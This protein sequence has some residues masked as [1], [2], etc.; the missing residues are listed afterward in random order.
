MSLFPPFNRDFGYP[1]PKPGHPIHSKRRPLPPGPLAGSIA[2]PSPFR[3][4]YPTLGPRFSNVNLSKL[5]IT[6]FSRPLID[7]LERRICERRLMTGGPARASL[8]QIGPVLGP[9]H[10]HA[11]LM[12]LRLSW[13]SDQLLDAIM[14]DARLQ[15]PLL[16]RDYDADSESSL[17]EVRR[18][19]H[20]QHTATESTGPANAESGAS[21]KGKGAAIESTATAQP[22]PGDQ[23]KRSKPSTHVPS[24]SKLLH[25]AVD[26]N[27]P[28][29]AQRV[30]METANLGDH[31]VPMD[32][33]DFSILEFAHLMTRIPIEAARLREATLD[34]ARCLS[35]RIPARYVR[36]LADECLLEYLD[37][38]QKDAQ[39]AV[40]D[41]LP[42]WEDY[43]SCSVAPLFI[44]GNLR[45]STTANGPDKHGEDGGRCCS[46]Q[47]T[48][49]GDGDGSDSQAS[50]S[51]SMSPRS[52]VYY[53]D[54]VV[55]E[56]KNLDSMPGRPTGE[57][58]DF[59]YIRDHPGTEGATP[60][61]STS[62]YQPPK[63][64]SRGDTSHSAPSDGPS[65]VAAHDREIR[66]AIDKL[67]L[68]LQRG[69]KD[70]ILYMSTNLD[71]ASNQESVTHVR[72][73]LKKKL[74]HPLLHR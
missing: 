50:G 16:S 11:N 5:P 8:Y 17:Y 4:A 35:E 31:T 71:P 25:A 57:Q 59:S 2:P 70:G 19:C 3:D 6:L 30:D 37:K 73:A 43:M 48:G 15:P 74:D 49:C 34:A 7:I 21:R 14:S 66:D 51:G 39:S 28:R 1:G 44:F 64:E 46:S 65:A 27:P 63:V 42:V 33:M 24:Y 62:N 69:K 41:L 58:S 36:Q 13:F 54:R 10:S 9:E 22:E 12:G 56:R 18:A 52:Y 38:T 23:K 26:R 40:E 61:L 55:P 53:H 72:Y 32:A 60:I 47:H 45:P 29:Q 67:H 68:M 20:D